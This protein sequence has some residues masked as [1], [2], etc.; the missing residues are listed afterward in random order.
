MSLRVMLTALLSSV[1]ITSMA[2]A[3]CDTQE[4]GRFAANGGE[5]YDS[6]AN[7][8][9]SVGQRWEG[10]KCTGAVEGLTWEQARKAAHDTWRLPTREELLTLIEQPCGLPASAKAVF[11]AFDPYHP[12]YWSSSAPDP[13]LAFEVGFDNGA[14]FDGYRTAPNAVRLVRVGK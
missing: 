13:D 3:A 9:C 2:Y 6:K 14:I 5:V 12:S 7:L 11:P 1:A 8:T 4:A 10:D